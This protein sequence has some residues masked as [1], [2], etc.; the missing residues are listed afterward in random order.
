[1][2]LAS[3]QSIKTT[4]TERPPSKTKNPT[5]PTSKISVKGSNPTPAKSQNAKKT[6]V[7]PTKTPTKN[8]PVSNKSDCKPNQV[9][10]SSKPSSAEAKESAKISTVLIDKPETLKYIRTNKQTF[11]KDILNIQVNLYL[12]RVYSKLKEIDKAK[13]FYF[14]VIKKEPNV[15][16]FILLSA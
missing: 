7:L 11:D 5:L 8:L 6:V 12:G 10:P 4:M 1:M 15:V 2:S 14:T 9:R 3:I 13:N 16:F